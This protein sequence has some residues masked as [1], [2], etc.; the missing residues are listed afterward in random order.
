MT[1]NFTETQLR[2]NVQKF[3]RKHPRSSLFPYSIEAIDLDFK[4]FSLN[5]DQNCPYLPFKDVGNVF[6]AEKA[7]MLTKL[8]F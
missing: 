3:T 8:C 5:H 4:M 2:S 1:E 7:E 6:L